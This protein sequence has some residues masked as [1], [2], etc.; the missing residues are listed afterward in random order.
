MRLFLAI[1]PSGEVLENY[2]SIQKQL[3]QYHNYIRFTQEDQIH[4]TVKFLGSINNTDS[5]SCI[6]KAF[7]PVIS[8]HDEFNL[9]VKELRYGFPGRRYPRILYASIAKS[10]ALDI[11][12]KDINSISDECKDIEQIIK[13]GNTIHH[14]TLARTKKHVTREIISN[15]RNRIDQVEPI[16]G[17]RVKSVKLVSSELFKTGPKH[18]IIQNFKLRE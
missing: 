7:N 10:Q 9:R 18:Q 14:F 8:Q 11:L 2:L 16:E 13:R 15:I 6:S 5:L 4:M 1:Y 3:T 12:V 17:F